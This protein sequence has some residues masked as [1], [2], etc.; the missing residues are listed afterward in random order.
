M[1]P[2]EMRGIYD[3]AAPAVTAFCQ[4]RLDGR[5]LERCL[6]AL[7]KLCGKRPSPLLGGDPKPWAA[8]IACFACAQ[9]GRFV[10]GCRNRLYAGEVAGPFRLSVSA[11]STEAAQIRKL[12]R[13][14]THNERCWGFDDGANDP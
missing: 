14:E 7:E 4:A 5:C 10:R 6:A 2:K 1:I 9:N 11:A 3:C 12:F 13:V 8:G